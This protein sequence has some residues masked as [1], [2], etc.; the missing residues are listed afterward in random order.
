[1]KL[2]PAIFLAGFALLPIDQTLCAQQILTLSSNGELWSVSPD[3]GQATI[4]GL[5]GVH[6][7]YWNGLTMDSQGWLYSAYGND[8]LG[9]SIYRINPS[10][11]SATLAVATNFSEIGSMAF[12]QTGVLYLAHDPIWPAAGGIYELYTL[13]LSSGIESFVGSTGSVN[14]LAMDFCGDQLYAQNT[15]NGLLLID[16][17]TG[18]ATDVNPNVAGPLG[19][20]MSM[21]FD[22]Q[23]ALYYLDHA[24]WVQDKDSGIRNPIDW[25]S[26]L[27]WWGEAVFVEGPKPNF[28]LWLDGTAGHFMQVKM[29]GATPN[30]QVGVLWAKGEGGP[31]PIPSGL[32][33]A[34]TMMDLNSNMKLLTTATADANGELVIGPGPTRVPAAA[35]GLIWLQAIDVSTCETSNK[36]LLYF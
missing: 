17:Y 23:G 29:T 21:C 30:A 16:T 18:V 28:A 1:M 26:V 19:A 8:W 22:D 35:A 9:F 3:N 36:V 25:V 4:I 11:G 13:D 14:L 32:P 31:T 24:I 12:D 34:G 27:G 5:T 33:C 20:T 10:N 6:G 2:H 7:L 15:S